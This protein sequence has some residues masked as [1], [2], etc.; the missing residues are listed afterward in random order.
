MGAYEPPQAAKYLNF[1]Q[2]VFEKKLN[3]E[4]TDLFTVCLNLGQKLRIEIFVRGLLRARE[5]VNQ[6]F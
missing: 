4:Y 2:G 1:C 6:Y 5:I 3:K